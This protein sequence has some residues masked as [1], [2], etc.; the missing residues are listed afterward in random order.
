MKKL[1]IL[2]DMDDTI[3]NL[4]DAWV[5]LLN[6]RYGLSVSMDDIKEWDMT[7]A[8]PTLEERQ[9]YAP[10]FEEELWERVKPLP[11]AYDYIAKL[12]A[13]GH[14]VCIVTASHYNSLPI[15]L[16]K[17]L[18]R[19]FPYLRYQDVIVAYDKKLIRGDILVDDYPKNLDGGEYHKIL[20]T[21]A[22]NRNF[23]EDTIGAVRASSWEEVFNIVCDYAR[24]E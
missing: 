21:A 13:N 19:Y 11:G 16:E 20:M 1:T 12:I 2:V 9:I 17:V 4:C 7:K 14:R 8:F 18:F 22:H 15:K 23:D 24:K 6:E 3:E 10:L 5:G